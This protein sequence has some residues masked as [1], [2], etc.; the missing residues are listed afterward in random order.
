MTIAKE[1]MSDSLLYGPSFNTSGAAPSCSEIT[2]ILGASHGIQV[3]SDSSEAKV[4][5]PRITGVVHEDV[6]LGTCQ[7]GRETAVRTITYP[8]KVSM[9]HIP[10]VEVAEALSNVR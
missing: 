6:R 2:L 1:K 8:F 3:Q 7:Y 10:G 4:R 5:D 9:D